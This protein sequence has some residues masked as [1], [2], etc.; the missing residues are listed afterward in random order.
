M[1]TLN[2][3]SIFVVDVKRLMRDQYKDLTNEHI[4]RQIQ[5]NDTVHRIANDT[6]RSD[7][8]V[9]IKRRSQARIV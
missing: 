6:K 1:M 2:P 5:G 9:S 3:N 7:S 4:G 8:K